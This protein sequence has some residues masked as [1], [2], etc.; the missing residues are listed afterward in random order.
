VASAQ[1]LHLHTIKS[2]SS[3]PFRS[4]DRH[5]P[6]YVPR[7]LVVRYL[8]EYAASFDLKPHFGE[9]VHAVR[10]RG[11][12]WLIESASKAF[13]ARNLV[14]A[15]GLNA[16]PVTPHYPGAEKFRGH[17]LHGGA[18][19]NP[20]PFTGRRVLVV[21][22]GNTGAEIALDL[23]EHG[24]ETTVSIRGGVHIVPRDLF[25]LPIQVVATVATH[26]LPLKI[27]DALFPVIL[28]FALGN[29]SKHGIKRPRQG[30]LEQ[31]V[32][33]GKI[34]VLDVGTAKR[35]R[36]ERLK[37]MK[38]IAAISEDGVI[39]EGGEQ[40][41][42]HSII[43]AT[44][45]RTG[46]QNFLHPDDGLGPQGVDPFTYF[47]GFRNPVTGLLW[48]ISKEAQSVADSIAYRRGRTP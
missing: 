15:S 5:Y 1:R 41:P 14:V 37:I 8:E 30:I 6:R 23:C 38:G 19:I 32:K 22:M 24:A 2:R 46:Y 4:F 26:L 25:G 9:N 12:E 42:F 31:V 10:K 45:Y 35:I 39:F 48:E 17:I 7:A 16:E 29:L 20:T 27:N 34:P 11:N 21:G 33:S 43:F 28:D 40:H 18:Y 44:G 3:L 13:S 47:V 36:D